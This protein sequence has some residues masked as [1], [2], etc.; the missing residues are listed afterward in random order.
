MLHGHAVADKRAGIAGRTVGRKNLPAAKGRVAATF[1]T[2]MRSPILG[3]RSRHV[4]RLRRRVLA[5]GDA[6]V[7]ARS[8][9]VASLAECETEVPIAGV[10]R[11]LWD[12]DTTERGD[13]IGCEAARLTRTKTLPLNDLAEELLGA[14]SNGSHD[15]TGQE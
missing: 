13:R 9:A 8:R 7:Q 3:E 15:V 6:L 12:L 1:S 11:A 14:G 2:L 5:V 10:N 4:P